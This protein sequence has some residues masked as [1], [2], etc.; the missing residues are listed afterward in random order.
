MPRAAKLKPGIPPEK[1]LQDLL[2]SGKVT[3]TNDPAR[4]YRDYRMARHFTPSGRS[5]KGV[6]ALPQDAWTAIPKAPSRIAGPGVEGLDVG[7]WDGADLSIPVGLCSECFTV[8]EG[9]FN[10]APTRCRVC[11]T[12][13]EV[14][15][16]DPERECCH[17]H[18]TEWGALTHHTPECQH[19]LNPPFGQATTL[20]RRA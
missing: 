10:G 1:T 5:H 3:L 13:L 7:T 11:G 18:C 19:R 12:T 20:L 4:T 6:L 17:G 2:T 14:P 15:D 9:G 16:S 8:R